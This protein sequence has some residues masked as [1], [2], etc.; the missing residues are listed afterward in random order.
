[1]DQRFCIDHCIA[2]GGWTRGCQGDAQFTAS[3]YV[4]ITFTASGVLCSPDRDRQTPPR[5]RP[6]YHSCG[7]L[8]QKREYGRG[9]VGIFTLR[10]R[11]ASH[12]KRDRQLR[13]LDFRPPAIFCRER[14]VRRW[15]VGFHLTVRARHLYHGLGGAYANA[16]CVMSGNQIG[17]GGYGNQWILASHTD[18]IARV[19]GDEFSLNV[20]FVLM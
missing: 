8:L 19:I 20:I 10:M 7:I 15:H 16:G 1:M 18:Y 11:K 13:L 2:P 9:I 3:H 4:C 12:P 6:M 17:D 5:E 14:H